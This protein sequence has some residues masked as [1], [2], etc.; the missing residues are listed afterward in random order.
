M[1]IGFEL[2]KSYIEEK[3]T[4]KL[5]SVIKY[6]TKYS[7]YDIN[8]SFISKYYIVEVRIHPYLENTETKTCLVEIADFKNWLK[9]K[10]PKVIWI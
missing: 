10:E 4:V 7:S 5:D 3:S 8:Y 1:K 6:G 9:E 2:L